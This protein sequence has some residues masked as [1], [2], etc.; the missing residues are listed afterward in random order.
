MNYAHETLVFE[1][2]LGQ[3]TVLLELEKAPVTAN[4]FRQLVLDGLLDETYVFRIV[5]SQNNTHNRACP[6]SVVQCGLTEKDREQLPKIAHEATHATGLT[7]KKWS[8]SAARIGVGE[9]YGSFFIVMDDEPSLDHGGL[10]H[11][12]GQGFAVFGE[13]TSGFSTLEKIF[14]RAEPQE[15]L[16]HKI[17]ITKARVA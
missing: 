1:T 9:T 7:H 16:H 12:D 13:I 2:A 8:V 3:F 14:R 17:S 6:I 4:Y 15:Y 5:N 11:P 10:R